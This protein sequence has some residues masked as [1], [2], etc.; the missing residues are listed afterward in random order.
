MV[1]G[2]NAHSLPHND[3]TGDSYYRAVIRD[4][5]YHYGACAN[6]GIIPYINGAKHFS[7][8]SYNNTV[9][10]GRMPLP[11]FLAGPA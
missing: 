4:R 1:K 11:F 7:A 5:F 6:P 8:G 9:T 3:S 10:D 2:I